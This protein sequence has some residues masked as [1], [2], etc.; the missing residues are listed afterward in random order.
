MREAE[1]SR[2]PDPPATATSVSHRL[3]KTDRASCAGQV[4]GAF[5]PEAVVGI[6]LSRTPRL[7][8]GTK[9]RREYPVRAPASD[10]DR[11]RGGRARRGIPIAV[12]DRSAAPL[13]QK[14]RRRRERARTDSSGARHRLGHRGR[15]GR[16]HRKETCSPGQACTANGNEARIGRS[17]GGRRRRS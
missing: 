7:I 14:A 16:R 3:C 4:K 15:H 2:R 8:P 13:E 11:I 12:S 9:M 5:D 6:R 1:S 17:S 10:F